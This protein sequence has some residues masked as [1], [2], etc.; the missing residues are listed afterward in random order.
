MQAH[1]RDSR[2]LRRYFNIEE[3]HTVG[4]LVCQLASFIGLSC[5]A[6]GGLEIPK[7]VVNIC[8]PAH[9]YLLILDL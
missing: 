3:R 2:V 6:S 9:M 1:A 4:S 5:T 7:T 8:I